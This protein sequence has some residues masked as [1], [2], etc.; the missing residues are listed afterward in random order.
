MRGRRLPARRPESG[1][2]PER[3]AAA[4]VPGARFRRSVSAAAAAR[5]A[6]GAHFVLQPRSG[7]LIEYSGRRGDGA[8]NGNGEKEKQENSIEFRAA[9]LAQSKQ[10]SRPPSI[11][12]RGPAGR[13][14]RPR[15]GRARGSRWPM[16][17]RG[18]SARSGR[19]VAPI[20][21]AP[22]APAEARRRVEPAGIILQPRR[23]RPPPHK[24]ERASGRLRERRKARPHA[25][26]QP[27]R[28]LLGRAGSHR[29]LC[30]RRSAH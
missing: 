24:N 15:R 10:T 18:R 22:H 11:R 6:R 29:R 3:S 2:E 9:P 13:R 20:E 8:G 25:A 4:R 12:R 27:P 14:T 28:R 30:R 5:A 17:S 19:T 21:L 1:A 23:R 26:S 7:D 16:G